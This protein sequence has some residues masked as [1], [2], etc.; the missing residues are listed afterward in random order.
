MKIGSLCSGYGGLDSAVSHVFSASVAWHTEIDD[1][2][3]HVLKINHPDVPN[4]GNVR[5][6]DWWR[7]PRVD[8]LSAGFPCQPWSVAGLQDGTIDYRNLWPV[9][10]RPAIIIMRPEIVVLEN[11]P[12]LVSWNSGTMFRGILHDLWTAGYR[13]RWGIFGACLIGACHHRHRMFLIGIQVGSTADLPARWPE[14]SCGVPRGTLVPTP[15]ARDGAEGGREEGS[16][17]YWASR[18][19]RT[20]GI[21]LGAAMALLPTPRATDG[22]NGG[23]GQRGS[24][25]DLAMPSAVQ[26]RNFGKYAPAIRIWTDRHGLPPAPTAVGPRGGVRLAAE[27]PEWMMG[28]PRGYVTDHV[29]RNVALQ[30]IGNGVMSQ[31]AEHALTTLR[32]MP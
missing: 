22:T 30:M 29:S 2:A 9:A 20:N 32:E 1:G 16:P 19:D 12:G 7:R 21:P 11:V 31:Q 4:L 5:Y 17:E 6:V 18:A 3:N 27:F 25:G 28:L 24:S 13:V 10:I 23:P 15:M 26:P 14:K 8:I